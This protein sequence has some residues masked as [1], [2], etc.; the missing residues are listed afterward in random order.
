MTPEEDR[1]LGRQR[2]RPDITDPQEFK[3]CFGFERIEDRQ[4]QAALDV[5]K[6][7]QL[8]E[9]RAPRARAL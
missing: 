5:L 3:E 8:I 2:A 1:K 7:V 4:L 6:G 9:M